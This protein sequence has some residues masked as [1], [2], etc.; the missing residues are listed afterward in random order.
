MCGIDG[1]V[2]KERPE[3]EVRYTDG[4]RDGSVGVN[5]E[6]G[7]AILAVAAAVA[8]VAAAASAL[9]KVSVGVLSRS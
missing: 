2:M 8:S 5:G 1:R 6:D 4:F 7:F 9:L 3:R